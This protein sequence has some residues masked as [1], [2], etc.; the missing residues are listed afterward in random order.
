[1]KFGFEDLEVWHLASELIDEVYDIADKFPPME[2][3]N[4]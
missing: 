3:Y 1:M 4:L 2:L